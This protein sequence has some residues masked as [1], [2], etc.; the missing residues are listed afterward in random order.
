MVEIKVGDILESEA[1]TLVNTVNCVG[2]M[3]KGIALGFKKKFPDMYD[4]YLRR[5]ENNEVKLGQPYLYKRL[6]KPWVINF[7]T[8]VHWRSVSRVVDIIKGLELIRDK[9]IEWG[10]QSIAVPPLGCGEGGL[11]WRVVGRVL[12][13]YVSKFD[14]TVELFAPHG[15]PR[16]ELKIE[17]LKTG[18]PKMVDE[19]LGL[20]YGKIK[21]AWVALAEA[22]ARIDSNAYGRGVGRVT[23]QKLAYLATRE[24]LPTGLEFERGSYGPFSREGK[25]VLT[26][27]INNGVL[28]EE[29]ISNFFSLK[30]GPAFL[31]T[32]EIYS[33]KIDEWQRIIDKLAD[34][35][36]RINSR[37]AELIT[38][39][40]YSA[41]LKKIKKGTKPLEIELFNEVS[42]WKSRRK[43]RFSDMDIGDTIR[44]LAILDWIDVD[45]SPELPVNP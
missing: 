36:V 41:D 31:E 13:K 39:I 28:E 23:F 12:Y 29:P 19:I 45:P 30:P 7:P 40:I 43:P 15:T 5:C 17:F 4:D 20:D 10:I 1:Q 26:K 37:Q 18:D 3:G 2:V 32:R 16:S 22:V 14:I 33:E 8:K 44:G 34:L 6:V 35:F 9:Y 27:L 42:E 11:E 24:G 25:M 21:S 38:T